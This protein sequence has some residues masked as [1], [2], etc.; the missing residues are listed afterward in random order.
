MSYEPTPVE[1]ATMIA[2]KIILD[3]DSPLVDATR[4][5][6]ANQHRPESARP[7]VSIRVY[8]EQAETD[9]KKLVA[10]GG[11]TTWQTLYRAPVDL[12]AFGPGADAILRWVFTR[13]KDTKYIELMHAQN[14][15]MSARGPINNM[16][17]SVGLDTEPRSMLRAIV[18]TTITENGSTDEL[19]L[20]NLN[21]STEDISI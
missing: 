12:Q 11:A 4:L 8:S 13:Q 2:L 14:V 10:P 6:F 9:T 7:F 1:A 19:R 18:T 20:V 5:W 3:D 17:A 15:Q 16:S 21:D